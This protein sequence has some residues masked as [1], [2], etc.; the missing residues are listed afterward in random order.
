MVVYRWGAGGALGRSGLVGHRGASMVMHRRFLNTGIEGVGAE[1]CVRVRRSLSRRRMDRHGSC[2]GGCIEGAEGREGRAVH[3]WSLCVS[4]VVHWVGP[5]GGGRL[6]PVNS[7][8][9]RLE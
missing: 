1:W 3:E 9:G 8:M 7:T 2:T 6:E 5:L 4:G